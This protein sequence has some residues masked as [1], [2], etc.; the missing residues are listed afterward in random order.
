MN[1]SQSCAARSKAAS[2]GA[3]PASVGPGLITILN[4]PRLCGWVPKALMLL[5]LAGASGIVEITVSGAGPDGM[6]TPVSTT[7]AY[8]GDSPINRK[9]AAS[10]KP[11]AA[12][13]RSAHGK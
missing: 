2:A 12:C 7:M 1:D 11:A 9:P 6:I 5:P 4:D 13:A 8:A 10:A 3:L